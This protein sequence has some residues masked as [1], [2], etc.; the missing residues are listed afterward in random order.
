MHRRP[1]SASAREVST[2]SLA[3]RCRSNSSLKK[4][5]SAVRSFKARFSRFSSRLILMRS[6]TFSSA[7][8]RLSATRVTLHGGSQHYNARPFIGSMRKERATQPLRQNR[9]LRAERYHAPP[10][11]ETRK[12][13]EVLLDAL[14][15]FEDMPT[16]MMQQVALFNAGQRSILPFAWR[17]GRASALASVRTTSIILP[18]RSLRLRST[19]D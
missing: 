10:P 5:R 11:T 2:C 1:E 15:A 18:Q 17:D 16:W 13:P 19:R 12:P 8:M 14:G 4:P 6:F 9:M 3:C 7:R